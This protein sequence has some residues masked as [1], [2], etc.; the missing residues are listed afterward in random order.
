MTYSSIL[1]PNEE[2]VNDCFFTIAAPN[3]SNL[4]R[5]V[6]H[7]MVLVDPIPTNH[8]TASLRGIMP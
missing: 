4:S 1:L 2:K 6:V 8:S 3:P 5:R 7:C